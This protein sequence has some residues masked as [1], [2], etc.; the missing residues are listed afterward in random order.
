MNKLIDRIQDI[1]YPIIGRIECKYDEFK[2]RCLRFKQG[3]SYGDVWDLHY[4]F[5]KTVRP[6]LVHLRDHGMGV[7]MEFY[8]HESDNER[9][10]WEN[11]LSEMIGCLDLMDEDKVYKLLGFDD[12]IKMAYKDNKR[13]GEIMNQNKDRFFELFS[14]YFY[15]LWD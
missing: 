8:A 1:Y 12:N 2:G 15:N 5:I 3:Y 9:I 6:M 4:W 7:P 10:Y 13:V 14:K 11:I